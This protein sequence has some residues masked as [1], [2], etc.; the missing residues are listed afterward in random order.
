ML[1]VANKL[2]LEEY[3]QVTTLETQL[4]A[5]SNGYHFIEVSVKDD[6]DIQEKSIYL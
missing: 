2:D 6:V 5:K 3:R 4:F 1:I